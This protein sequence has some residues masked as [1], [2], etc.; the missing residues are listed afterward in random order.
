MTN[1]RLRLLL[2]YS[3]LLFILTAHAQPIK[4]KLDS[5]HSLVLN[6]NSQ[7]TN[8]TTLQEVKLLLQE[9]KSRQQRHRVADAYI[10]L[11]KI[12]FNLNNEA[13]ALKYFK[14]YMAETNQLR[15]DYSSAQTYKRLATYENEVK[16]LLQ[17]QDE[18][19][20]ANKQLND[21]KEA[22]LQKNTFIYYGLISSIIIGLIIIFLS[23]RRSKK[24]KQG[25][26]REAS[27]SST[28]MSLNHAEFEK[29]I[30]ILEQELQY[31]DLLT[32]QLE[33]KE[34]QQLKYLKYVK[35]T[36]VFNNPKKITGGDGLWFYSKKE[37]SIVVVF[38]V[39]EFGA[40][41]ALLASILKTMLNELVEE[42]QSLA[43]ALIL[44]QIEDKLQQ[45]KLAKSV[46]SEGIKLGVC[47]IDNVL[48][49][50]DYASADFSMYI[51]EQDKLNRYDGDVYPLLSPEREQGYFKTERVKIG[52]KTKLYMS[53]DGFWNQTG[54][55]D[56]LAFKQSGFEKA[57]I[58]M[59]NQAFEDQEFI[60]GKLF[61]NWK[62]SGAQTDDVLV[63]G[64][65]F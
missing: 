23:K 16:A 19:E 44:T 56:K 31:N 39:P 62:G 42:S 55:H 20:D 30:E 58:T 26:S 7:A 24:S 54:G 41:G 45:K 33:E 22:L 13:E 2:V 8:A 11:A 1:Q 25:S 5:L 12:S 27:T 43:P 3:L 50:V 48:M 18:L 17:V 36:F 47:T 15:L 53:T 52:K 14:L 32:E 51:V 34:Q 10:L 57:L 4:D 9:A 46:P 35:S 37:K 49:S 60:I 21:E 38:D 28:S 6:D 59:A 29:K 65:E 63:L 64:L 40:S 61:N